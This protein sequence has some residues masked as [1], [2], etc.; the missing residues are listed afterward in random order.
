MS[1]DELVGIQWITDSVMFV[2]NEANR[3]RGPNSTNSQNDTF[4]LNKKLVQLST[5]QK[6]HYSEYSS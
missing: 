5:K 4:D 3:L 6:A 2:D 1:L